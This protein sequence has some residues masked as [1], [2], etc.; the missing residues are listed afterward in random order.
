MLKSRLLAV[1][2]VPLI[3]LAACKEDEVMSRA[4]SQVE[5]S[6]GVPTFD[7]ERSE[8]FGFSWE[9]GL[10]DL[11]EDS[12]VLA[13]GVWQEPDGDIVTCTDWRGDRCVA[14]RESDDGIDMLEDMGLIGA[15]AVA[16]YGVSRT[17]KK[18]KPSYTTTKPAT[19][20][21]QLTATARA[22]ASAPV[23]QAAPSSTSRVKPN[24]TSRVKPKPSSRGSSWSTRKSSSS[25]RKKR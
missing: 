2:L 15:G 5:T 25:Y 6:F 20:P 7:L 24:P 9:E 14:T 13:R 22:E 21:A 16:G 1:A 18:P 11:D 23:R 12:D 4:T 19:R 3:A 8:A 17:I 10:D